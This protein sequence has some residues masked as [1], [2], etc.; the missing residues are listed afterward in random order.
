MVVLANALADT[1]ES[2]AGRQYV[3]QAFQSIGQNSEG[4]GPE[5]ARK[6]DDRNNSA[7]DHRQGSRLNKG[8]SLLIPFHFHGTTHLPKPLF[9]QRNFLKRIQTSLVSHPGIP[10]VVPMDSLLTENAPSQYGGH[11]EITKLNRPDSMNAFN[12]QLLE[13][14]EHTVVRIRSD[15]RLRVWIITGNGRAFCAG[16]DLKQRASLSVSE[17]HSFLKRLGQLCQDIET[18]PF[19]TIA[20]INGYALGG[21]LEL[22]LCFDFRIALSSAVLGLTETSL[23]IIPG[24]GGTQRLSR[25]IG[26]A[27]AKELIFT[28]RKISAEK[29]RLEHGRSDLRQRPRSPSSGKICRR[30]RFRYRLGFRFTDRI[31]SLSG[32]PQFQGPNRSLGRLS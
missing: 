25:L 1:V 3:D 11:F 27:S 31:P 7:R 32:D 8:L 16:A 20:A 23:G 2:E 14:L 12:F 10:P 5:V 6:L 18:L 13:E 19:P 4:G 28:A 21:G 17:V 15:P 9:S 24:A 29:A 30:S 22:A 26:L